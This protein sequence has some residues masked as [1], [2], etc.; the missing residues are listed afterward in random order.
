MAARRWGSGG[1][2]GWRARLEHAAHAPG[3]PT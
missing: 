2:P 3:S 1:G